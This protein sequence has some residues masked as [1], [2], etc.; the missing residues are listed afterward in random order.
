MNSLA[1]HSHLTCRWP[2]VG[3]G[4]QILQSDDDRLQWAKSETPAD[5]FG[6]IANVPAVAAENLVFGRI[7][8]LVQMN[9]KNSVVLNELGVVL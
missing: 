3:L 8:L 1:S 9:L 4:L 6:A 7:A 5:F 2:G